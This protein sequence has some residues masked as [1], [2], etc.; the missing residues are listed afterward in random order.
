MIL[1]IYSVYLLENL[2]DGVRSEPLADL[3]ALADPHHGYLLDG[4]GCELLV[5]KVAEYLPVQ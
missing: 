5:A 1:S 3:D 2:C 4:I